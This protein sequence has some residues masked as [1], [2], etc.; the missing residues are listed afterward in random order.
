[1]SFA[2]NCSK[3]VGRTE[4]R[5]ESADFFAVVVRLTVGSSAFELFSPALGLFVTGR[6][7]CAVISSSGLHRRFFSP[8]VNCGILSLPEVAVPEALLLVVVIGTVAEGSRERSKSL[9]FRMAVISLSGRETGE[10]GSA[11]RETL[12]DEEGD[13]MC[14]FLRSDA[15]S[16][17]DEE[18]DN[19][20]GR[21]LC[22][23]AAFREA[24]DAEEAKALDLVFADPTTDT[25]SGATRERVVRVV[26][27]LYRDAKLGRERRLAAPIGYYNKNKVIERRR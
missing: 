7:D 11:P 17:S 27:D 24:G 1:M 4:W 9:E 21:C 16:E 18:E 8:N 20:R 13:L 25:P 14:F 26:M 3:S 2:E 23:N 6:K 22:R 15:V 12:D 5:I 10:L 19:F